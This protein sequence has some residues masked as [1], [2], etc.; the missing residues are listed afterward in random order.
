MGCQI[1]TNNNVSRCKACDFENALPAN[2]P[3]KRQIQRAVLAHHAGD[4]RAAIWLRREHY[5]AFLRGVVATETLLRSK[6]FSWL[7]GGR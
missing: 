2:F 6:G 1:C 3:E 7:G 4:T 5:Y